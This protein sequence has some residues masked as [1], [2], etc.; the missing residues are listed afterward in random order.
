PRYTSCSS[1][2]GSPRALAGDGPATGGN[3]VPLGRA[4]ALV[5]GS[6]TRVPLAIGVHGAAAGGGG[7]RVRDVAAEQLDFDQRRT[8]GLEV[9]IGFQ[10]LFEVTSR[11][12]ELLLPKRRH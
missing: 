5:D 11:R 2:A 10:R 9:G 7:R 4:Q 6:E 3:L 8:G 1:A 12:L